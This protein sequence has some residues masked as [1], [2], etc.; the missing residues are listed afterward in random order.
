MQGELLDET[1]CVVNTDCNDRGNDEGR[2]EGEGSGSQDMLDFGAVV[3]LFS[4]PEACM[5]DGV[6]ITIYVAIADP[7][8]VRVPVFVS[9]SIS[10]TAAYK[11]G[12]VRYR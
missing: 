11:T 3:V 10:D 8:R 9:T 12:T 7:I 4:L 1:L 6:V 2:D 5:L